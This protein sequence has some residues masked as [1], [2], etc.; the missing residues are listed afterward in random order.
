MILY[1]L[2]GRII[3]VMDQLFYTHEMCKFYRTPTFKMDE[4][5]NV[6]NNIAYSKL[7]RNIVS[8]CYNSIMQEKKEKIFFIMEKYFYNESLMEKEKLQIME[9][10][11]KD[12]AFQLNLVYQMFKFQ[13]RPRD[14]Y[15]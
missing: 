1:E 7:K 2:N 5:S 11:K 8:N 4:S 9:R 13:N 15:I 12:C 6:I 10:M 3:W 14:E